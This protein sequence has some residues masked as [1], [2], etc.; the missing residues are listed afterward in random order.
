MHAKPTRLAVRY[1]LLDTTN[2]GENSSPVPDIGTTSIAI[3]GLI[4]IQA[5]TA[6]KIVKSADPVAITNRLD[7][8][9][10]LQPDLGALS[11]FRRRLAGFLAIYA[12]PLN[13]C[14]AHGLFY[15]DA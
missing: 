13:A 14:V 3:T 7:V 1:P 11:L 9:N 15:H 2:L 4:E 5:V 8:N 10:L 6:P 12:S